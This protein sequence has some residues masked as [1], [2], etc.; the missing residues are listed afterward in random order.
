MNKRLRSMIRARKTTNSYVKQNNQK[1]VFHKRL[2]ERYT[3][4]LQRRYFARLKKVIKNLI[5]GTYL[6]KY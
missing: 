2:K 3:K 5:T 4:T 6:K 1:Y